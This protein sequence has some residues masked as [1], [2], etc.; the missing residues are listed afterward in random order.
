[1]REPEHTH[2]WHG[3]LWFT[4]SLYRDSDE[5]SLQQNY[6]GHTVEPCHIDQRVFNTF[7]R[8]LPR[9]FKKVKYSSSPQDPSM[10]I[11]PYACAVVVESW[12]PD[13]QKDR[14]IFIASD[15]PQRVIDIARQTGLP[16][17]YL[18]ALVHSSSL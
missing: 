4:G 18:E 1:M 16:T 15:N 7:T 6:A 17:N 10:Y 11:S 3:A 9:E 8:K 14:H 2:S 12:T 5:R 13:K